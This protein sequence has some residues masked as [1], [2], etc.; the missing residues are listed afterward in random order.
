MDRERRT[1]S[2]P[3]GIATVNREAGSSPVTQ[4]GPTSHAEPTRSYG[5]VAHPLAVSLAVRERSQRHS[6]MPGVQH[7]SDL[8]R[9]R[10]DKEF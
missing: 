6:R 1:P 5:W 7:P 4:R 8:H 3:A 9:F 2:G 10:S